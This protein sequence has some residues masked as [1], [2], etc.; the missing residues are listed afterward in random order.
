M[1]S[2]SYVL[3]APPWETSTTLR[4]LSIV[5]DFIPSSTGG[6]YRAA[7]SCRPAEA[8]RHGVQHVAVARGRA[9]HDCASSLPTQR[10]RGALCGN[11]LRAAIGEVRLVFL[12]DVEVQML[13]DPALGEAVLHQPVGG[14]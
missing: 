8:C 10:D 12:P 6:S 2:A 3:P 11:D 1:A 9:G 5:Y 13:A 14:L 7:C 4:S